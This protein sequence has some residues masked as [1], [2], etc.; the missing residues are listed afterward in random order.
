MARPVKRRRICG[1]PEVCEFY[2]RER[3]QAETIRLTVDEFETIRLID[4]LG[5]SQEDCA[6]QMNVARTTV[7]YIYDSARKK[8]ADVIVGGMGLQIGGGSYEL[9]PN[10]AGCCKKECRRRS[11]CGKRCENEATG[12]SNE[13]CIKTNASCTKRI[14]DI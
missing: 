10:S 13:Q 2:P 5:L 11:G 8:L 7:Q 4:Q 12:N 14:I 6:V 3:E 9:C 1:M